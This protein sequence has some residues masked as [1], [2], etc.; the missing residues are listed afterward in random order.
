MGSFIA[1]IDP[2]MF[3]SQLTFNILMIVVVGGLGSVTGSLVGS[4]V[5]TVLLEWLRFVENTMEIG[6]ITILGIPGMRMFIFSLIL[7]FIILYRR[8]GIIGGYEFSWDNIANAF[9]WGKG[10]VLNA[11]C[12]T[13]NRRRHH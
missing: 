6:S 12:R 11:I 5:I 2:K 1:T 4:G 9:W 10:R 7:L 8:K 13:Q 3:N